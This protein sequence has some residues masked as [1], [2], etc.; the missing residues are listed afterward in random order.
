GIWIVF[1]ELVL[2]VWGH[3]LVEVT[4]SSV[5]GRRIADAMAGLISTVFATWLAWILLDTAILRALSPATSR[6][7]PSTR[8]RTILP[9]LRN[10]L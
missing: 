5:N 7:Q 9:L 4:H 10:G 6:A 8:A 1:V 3:T 2:R